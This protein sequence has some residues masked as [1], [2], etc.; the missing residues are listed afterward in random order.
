[1]KTSELLKLTPEELAKTQF[2]E[3]KK[4][5]IKRLSEIVELL[6]NTHKD[7]QDQLNKYTDSSPAG[8]GMGCDNSFISF[9]DILEVTDD[10]GTDFKDVL[11]RLDVL[12]KIAYK[13]EKQ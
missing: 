1:M 4:E 11:E 3:L 9:S 13:G 10:R 7:F 8:D 5:T 12:Q 6:K 2:K